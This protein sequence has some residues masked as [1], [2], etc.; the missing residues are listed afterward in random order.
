MDRQELTEEEL[1]LIYQ[2]LAAGKWDLTYSSFVSFLPAAIVV[3]V[4]I[5][6]LDPLWITIGIGIHLFLRIY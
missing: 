1:K 3:G 5:S 4:G 6:N 2:V